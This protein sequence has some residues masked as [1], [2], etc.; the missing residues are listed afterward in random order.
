MLR[1]V[2]VA[3]VCSPA[4]LLAG[5]GTMNIVATQ[6]STGSGPG[7][8]WTYYGSYPLPVSTFTVEIKEQS[9]GNTGSGTP[10]NAATGTVQH[11]INI[12]TA[13]GTTP[14]ISPAPANGGTGADKAAASAV[15]DGFKKNYSDL[16][17]RYAT[18]VVQLSTDIASFREELTAKNLVVE[19][20]R[21]PA[22]LLPRAQALSGRRKSLDALYR[23]AIAMANQVRATCK[24]AI[25]VN[26]TQDVAG[27][28][29]HD[30]RAY[31][32]DDGWSHITLKAKTGANGLLTSLTTTAEDATGAIV[33]SAVQTLMSFEGTLGP[34]PG[35]AGPPPNY[36]VD[37]QDPIKRMTEFAPPTLPSVDALIVIPKDPKVV[38]LTEIV[39]KTLEVGGGVE[40]TATCG[41]PPRTAQIT[42]SSDEI[43][44]GL[45]T[46]AQ[47]SC[48]LTANWSDGLRHQKR[49]PVNAL[50][51][52]ITVALPVPQ[53][54]LVSRPTTYSFEGGRLTQVEYDKPSTVLAAVTL[55]GKALT[56]GVTALSQA[57]VGRKSV[58]QSRADELQAQAAIVSARAKLL[59][60]EADLAKSEAA[61]GSAGAKP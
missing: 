20:T 14:N 45:A 8:G 60:A 59:A 58:A 55:P 2:S 29:K 9:A 48:V 33:L 31:V 61:A 38:K 27:D 52:S 37:Y 56:D 24:I 47:R 50:D 46:S 26:I 44:D 39:G 25:S 41:A 18:N 28:E 16:A 34:S 30:Y 19:P 36:D 10:T 4:L 12:S 21:L 40:L 1:H 17:Q 13:P 35:Y 15:C 7:P 57:I 49:V 43:V 53:T 23:Q 22:D 3:A 6:P 5:C 51:S 54:R 11:T 32:R 42:Q